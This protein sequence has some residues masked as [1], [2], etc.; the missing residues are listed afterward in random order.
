MTRK[1]FKEVNTTEP[2]SQKYSAFGFQMGINADFNSYIQG[3]ISAAEI[4]YERYKRADSTEIDVLDTLVYPICFLYRQIT[5]LYIKHI[6]IKYSSEDEKGKIAF[7]KKVSHRLK[8]AWEKTIPILKRLKERFPSFSVSIEECGELIEQIDEFDETSMRMRYPMTKDFR[9]TNEKPMLLD[10]D[11][12]NEGM[13]ELFEKLQEIC[14]FFDNVFPDNTVDS[15]FE[16][17]VLAKAQPCSDIMIDMVKMI[18]E[19]R[20]QES[21]LPKKRDTAIPELLNLADVEPQDETTVEKAISSI[22]REIG[23]EKIKYI[24]M[25][26]YTGCDLKNKRL[27]LSEKIDERKKDLI[28]AF[29]L[30][31]TEYPVL[32][33]SNDKWQ[34]AEKILS[35]DSQ[36]AV[37]VLNLILK[38]M[39]DTQIIK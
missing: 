2:H 16:I 22:I 5:E 39:H 32:R 27:K 30:K 36:Y 12:L 18:E 15:S 33:K 13:H 28:C 23:I 14:D 6:Y 3:Y 1:L 38:E 35:A 7:V 9:A 25:L 34:I 17:K 10:I 20:E 29:Q 24:M 31:M 21:T 37:S 26:F 4:V 19:L 11:N 8:L